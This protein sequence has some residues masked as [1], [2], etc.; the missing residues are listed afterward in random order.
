MEKIRVLLIEDD[1]V[2]RMAFRRFVASGSL[3]YDVVTA[4]SASEAAKLLKSSDF[5]VIITDYLLGDA[6][7]FD[8]LEPGLECPFIVITGAGSEEIAVRA[9]KAGAQD[10]VIKDMEH[11]YLKIL[12]VII[13]RAISRQKTEERYRLLRN[14]ET[15]GAVL[16]GGEGLADTLK[17]VNLAALSDAPVLITGETG[18]GKNVAAKAIH[19]GGVRGNSAFFSINC[20][21]LP[22]NLIESELFGYERGAF[23]GAAATKKGIF[24]MADGGTLLLDE[25]GEMPLHLQAKI[26][27]VIEEKKIRRLGGLQEMPVDVRI[28]AAT[29]IDL[30]DG[31]GKI[32]RQD[33]YFRLSVI[34]IH[35]PPLRARREDIPLLCA[36]LMKKISEGRDIRIAGPEMK[37]LMAY[38]WPGNVRE[39]GNILERAAILQEGPEIFPSAFLCSDDGRLTVLPVSRCGEDIMPLDEMEKKCIGMTLQRFSGNVTKTSEALKV[40]LSTLKRKIKAYDL[41]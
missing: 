11:N 37:K 41:K 30:E 3:P 39:L 19:Y 2:D 12:P 17:M 34:R 24:E 13:E 27:S 16:V 25:I 20:A 35:I 31:L 38:S 22:E 4:G 1:E 18:T 15:E 10:Y 14:R 33:L 7:A 8:V 40:P 29:G 32:F 23:T 6:T 9:M 5:D 26:L 21:S 36:H 28:I